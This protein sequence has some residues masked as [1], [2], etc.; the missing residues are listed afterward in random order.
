MKTPIRTN[1]TIVIDEAAHERGLRRERIA[2]ILAELLVIDEAAH[3][4]GLRHGL[5][6]QYGTL[7]IC[8][9]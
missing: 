3:E 9:R 1:P 8:H 5:P 2:E 4:R 7:G 6:S